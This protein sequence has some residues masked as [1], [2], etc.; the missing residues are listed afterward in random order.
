MTDVIKCCPRIFLWKNVFNS[1]NVKYSK[2]H[3]LC[4]ISLDYTISMVS[5]NEIKLNLHTY[6]NDASKIPLVHNFSVYSSLK[7]TISDTYQIMIQFPLC[8]WKINT[9]TQCN[10]GDSNS[11]WF[12]PCFNQQWYTLHSFSHIALCHYKIRFLWYLQ[13]IFITLSRF[14]FHDLRLYNIANFKPSHPFQ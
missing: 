14:Q 11:R 12:R 2:L 1:L 3:W 5:N 8:N 4:V 13:W 6:N 9:F 10:K 7:I